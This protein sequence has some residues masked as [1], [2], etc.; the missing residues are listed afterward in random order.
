[1]K[2]RLDFD[3]FN[4]TLFHRL[5]TPYPN[6]YTFSKNLGE[7]VCEDYHREKG[8]PIVIYRASI[9]SNAEVEPEPGKM[10][11]FN[12]VLAFIVSIGRCLI[13]STLFDI[14]ENLSLVSWRFSF[15]FSYISGISRTLHCIKGSGLNMI[16]VDL[17]AKG[18]IVAAWKTACDVKVDSDKIIVYN[19]STRYMSF[20]KLKAFGDSMTEKAP[21]KDMLWKP[22][23]L[24]TDSKTLANINLILFQVFP[25]L[26]ADLLLILNNRKPMFVSHIN[27]SNNHSLIFKFQNFE[28]FKEAYTR[29]RDRGSLRAENLF[30][31][32]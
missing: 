4:A 8:L 18:I 9:V 29:N 17:C 11:S 19:S 23:I 5:I 2:F 26:F 24:L 21:L 32:Q 7:H 16:P 1:M 12:G 25:G 15:Q 14:D 30:S 28:N 20:E 10:G 3:D 31:R 6:T 13:F 22:N 27:N